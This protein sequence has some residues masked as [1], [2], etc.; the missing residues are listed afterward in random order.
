MAVHAAR[1]LSKAPVHSEA[2]GKR[3]SLDDNLVRGLL[4]HFSSLQSSILEGYTFEKQRSDYSD[5]RVDLDVFNANGDLAFCG[6]EFRSG[7][8]AFWR[9]S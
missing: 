8:L 5:A 9:P 7:L 3:S 4:L 1:H 6:R 2:I